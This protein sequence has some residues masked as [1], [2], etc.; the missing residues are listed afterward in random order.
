MKKL[1]LTWCLL[2][3]ACAV[4]AQVRFE[5]VSTD[6]LREL[7]VGSGK[8]VFIDLYA[9][10]CRPCRMMER[11]V[12]SRRDVGEFMNR[13]FVCARYDTDKATGRELLKRYG[14]NAVPTFL[15]FDIE[16]QLLG[17]IQGASSAEEFLQDIRTVL[18]RQQPD[19]LK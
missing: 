19:R 5:P 1:L 15:I 13:Y 8:L 17:R 6:G 18:E 11:D 2:L 10:W 9:T 12:F 14:N 16:G 4:R 7:A 3:G